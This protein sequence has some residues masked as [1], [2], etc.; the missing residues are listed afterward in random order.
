[1]YSNTERT[2]KTHFCL[3]KIKIVQ[4]VLTFPEQPWSREGEQESASAE[5]FW[6]ELSP[7]APVRKIIQFSS[8]GKD[9]KFNQAHACNYLCTRFKDLTVAVRK[10]QF[11]VATYMSGSYPGCSHHG[12]VV[13]EHADALR[14]LRMSH[15]HHVADICTC[16]E[17]VT[18]FLKMKVGLEYFI[19]SHEH[20]VFPRSF[21]EKNSN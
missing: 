15:E 3:G 21:G 13:V 12:P 4:F 16:C 18:I 8:K 14:Q 19:N 5:P 7:E 11:N 6:S 9:N 10:P 20:F 17:D 2:Q 1:M